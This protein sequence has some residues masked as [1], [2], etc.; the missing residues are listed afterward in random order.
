MIRISTGL[1]GSGKTLH[2]V[3]EMYQDKTKVHFFSNI[4]TKGV[5]KNTTLKREMIYKKERIGEVKKRDGKIEPIYKYVLNLEFW[6]KVK[7]PVSII[8]DEAH[9]ILNAREFMSKKNNLVSSWVSLLR[10]IVQDK[11]TGYTG[12]LVLITQNPYRIDKNIR[13]LTTQI[14]H[15]TMNWLSVCVD[16]DSGWVENSDMAEKLKYCPVCCSADI[17]KKDYVLRI[18]FFNTLG[19]YD[20]WHIQCMKTYYKEIQVMDCEDYFNLYDTLQIKNFFD[21]IR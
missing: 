6:K 9:E 14:R 18:K 17:F 5:P 15:H 12:E 8:I 21:D 1:L 3:R 10:R 20:L 4:L 11:E 7:K 2:E 19:N 13:D 16:C